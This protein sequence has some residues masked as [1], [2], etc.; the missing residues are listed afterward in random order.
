MKLSCLQDNLAWGLNIVGQAVSTRPTLPVLANIML[1]A[2]E[3]RLRLSA[4]NLDI[5]IHCWIEA[6]V[7]EEGATTV[8]ARLLSDFVGGLPR[9]RIDLTLN[10]RTQTL[11]L[12]CARFEANVKGI[13]ARE[14]PLIPTAQEV[15][16]EEGAFTCLLDADAFGHIIKQVAFAASTDE[17]RPLLN[18]ILAKFQDATLTLA[19]ADGFRLAVRQAALEKPAPNPLSII[20][21][22]RSLVKLGRIISK[23]GPG[24]ELEMIITPNRNQVLFRLGNLA[25]VELVSQLI[26]GNFPDYNQVIPRSYDT[27]AVVSTAAFLKAARMAAIFAQERQGEP[28]MLQIP[29]GEGR[30]RITTASE[31]GEGKVEV[32][33]EVETRGET[34]GSDFEIAFHAPYLIDALAAMDAEQMAL[35]TTTPESPGLLRPVGEGEGEYLCLIMP[36]QV[37]R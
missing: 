7:E 33:A 32:E 14:F 18:G 6:K 31:A 2:E 12:R 36:M 24:G 34:S 3:G 11:N 26:E 17:N 16:A 29:P 15:G 25:D 27:R 35:E 23:V 19:A 28:L 37:R 9:E 30:M 21:P 10:V 22:A 5:G 1:E 4:T 8:P 20:I 13:D